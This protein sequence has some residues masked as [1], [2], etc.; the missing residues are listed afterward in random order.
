MELLSNCRFEDKQSQFLCCLQSIATHR[1]QL[2][3]SSFCPLVCLSV[4]PSVT[5]SKGIFRRRHMHSSQCCH[6]SNRISMCKTWCNSKGL[7]RND[8]DD[9]TRVNDLM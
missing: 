3:P 2:C 8:V 7:K 6:Y 5:L 9:S 1:D 4:R